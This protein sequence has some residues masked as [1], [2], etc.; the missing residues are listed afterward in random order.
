MKSRNRNSR[1]L[2]TYLTRP[3]CYCF[4]VFALLISAIHPALLSQTSEIRSAASHPRV[5]TK[6]SRPPLKGPEAADRMEADRQHN[7]HISS[8]PAT[9]TL[10]GGILTV[11]ADNS[12]LSQILQDVAKVSGMTV[13]GSIKNARVFGNYGPRNPSDVIR[14][15][16]TGSGYNFIMLGV[17]NEGTPRQLLLSLKSGDSLGVTVPPQNPTAVTQSEGS[18]ANPDTQEKLGPGA[19]IN[20]PPAPPEDPEE[21]TRQNLQRLEQMRDPRNQPQPQ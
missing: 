11:E 10:K 3:A 21:R 4:A 5:R 18:D 8:K 14:E 16:L 6:I 2:L 9:V 15:L 13:E 19:I 20:V 1:E 7:D 12:D 17:T